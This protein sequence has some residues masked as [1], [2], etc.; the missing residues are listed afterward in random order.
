M[1][2]THIYLLGRG[3]GGGLLPL[4]LP[5]GL[6][7]WLGKFGTFCLLMMDGF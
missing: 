2:K 6:P 3:G 4:P 7:L 5:E 1:G